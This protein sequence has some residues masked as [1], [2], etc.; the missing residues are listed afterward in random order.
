MIRCLPVAL[1]VL[2]LMSGVAAQGPALTPFYPACVEAYSKCDWTFYNVSSLP[3]YN[4]SA[5]ADT[6][7]TPLI[8]SKNKSVKLTVVNSNNAFTEFVYKEGLLPSVYEGKP[9]F[10]ISTFKPFQGINGSRLAHERYTG[11]QERV[12]SGRCLRV[13]FSSY[14]QLV[15]GRV[16]NVR[17]ARFDD[18]CVVFWTYAYPSA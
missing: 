6:A 18:K 8:V 1:A 16:E 17:V 4:I 11:N 10:R 2:M 13:Y 5:P 12:A 15:T 14:Q 3:T 9:R 7:F